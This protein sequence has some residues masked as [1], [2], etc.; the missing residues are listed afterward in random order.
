[1][2]IPVLPVRC[3]DAAA[4]PPPLTTAMPQPN[5]TH[6]VISDF[7]RCVTNKHKPAAYGQ[8]RLS[9]HVS[10]GEASSRFGLIPPLRMP[11]ADSTCQRG[12]CLHLES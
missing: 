6:T 2:F 10:V 12:L 11:Q 7:H 9:P 3:A 8:T 1:M 5:T 4:G